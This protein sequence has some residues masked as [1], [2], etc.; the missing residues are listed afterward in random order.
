MSLLIRWWWGR[1]E[2]TAAY[3]VVVVDLHR[4]HSCVDVE[5]GEEQ[6]AGPCRLQGAERTLAVVSQPGVRVETSVLPSSQTTSTSLSSCRALT[7][8]TRQLVTGRG[9][10]MVV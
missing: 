10:A 7:A 4:V 8:D 9:A 1:G 6:A 2:E 5:L 3:L